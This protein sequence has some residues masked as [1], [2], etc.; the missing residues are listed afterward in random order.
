MIASAGADV[1][2]E[3][4]GRRYGA[5]EA[6]RDANLHV[7][8]GEF[9]AV[10]GRSGSGKS[11]LLNLIGGLEQPTSGR[12]LIDGRELWLQPRAPRHRRELVGFVFQQHHLLASLTAQANVEVALLGA[13]MPRRERRERALELLAE[14]GLAERALHEPAQLSGGER[15]RVAIARALANEPRLLLADEP[16]GAVDSVTS[17]RVLD[18][19][20]EA[21]ARRGMTLIVV[22]YDPQVGDSADRMLT[23]TDGVLTLPETGLSAAPSA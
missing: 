17:Q 21:R 16:T 23:V 6:L 13:G 8:P 15:Q 5:V 3:H 14:V 1:R 19:L 11:T 20:G 9:V 7:A 12:I 2:V 22:S 4:A 18:L 10:T